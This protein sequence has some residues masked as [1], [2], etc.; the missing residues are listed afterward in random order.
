L[1]DRF[2]ALLQCIAVTVLLELL[3]GV[4]DVPGDLKSVE[5]ERL[6]GAEAEVGVEGEVA[7]QVRPTDLPPLRLEAVVGAEAIGAQTPL[8]SSPMRPCRC[9]LPRSGAIRKTAVCLPKAPQSVRGSPLR[10]QPVSSTLSAPAAR[11]CSSNSS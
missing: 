11:V 9:C 3:P 2:D 10:Y 1:L 7:T 8:K 6:L 5:P 4:E